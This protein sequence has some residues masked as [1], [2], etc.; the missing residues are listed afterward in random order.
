[1]RTIK[2]RG[3]DILT[4]KWVYGDLLHL[5]NACAIVTSYEEE[6]LEVNPISDRLEFRVE[7]IAGVYPETV[8]QFTG[9]YDK[10]GKMVYEGDI[11]HLDA[12]EPYAMQV[13]FIEG[14]F[15]LADNDGRYLGDIHY[16][17]HAGVNQC[18]ILGNIHDNPELLK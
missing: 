4:D 13:K 11:V 9:I 6:E 10:E 5:G 17:N 2:F 15:A 18:T 8:G 12:W 14:A 1:M 16:I 7:D 3:K